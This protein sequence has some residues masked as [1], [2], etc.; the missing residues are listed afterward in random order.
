MV[1]SRWTC[2]VAVDLY[3]RGFSLPSSASLSVDDQ[4]AVV[5]RVT[6]IVATT[7]QLRN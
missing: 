7:R 6:G 5:E 2:T 3:R 4:R 1:T